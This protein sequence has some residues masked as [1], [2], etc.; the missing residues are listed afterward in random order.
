M[1][2]IFIGIFS[3]VFSSTDVS[4]TNMYEVVFIKCRPTSVEG[5]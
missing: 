4:W 5:V 1:S 3:C 2:R